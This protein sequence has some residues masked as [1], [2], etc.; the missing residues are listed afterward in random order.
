MAGRRSAPTINM[1][2]PSAANM[3]D[4]KHNALHRTMNDAPIRPMSRIYQE[5]VPERSAHRPMSDIASH[6]PDS[7][8]VYAGEVEAAR[9]GRSS[10]SLPPTDSD[11]L[12]MANK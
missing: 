1:V 6:P 10:S 7:D 3:T 2:E 9:V 5:Y 11:Y 12:R 4:A 8:N